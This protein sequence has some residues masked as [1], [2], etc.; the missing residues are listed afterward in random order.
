MDAKLLEAAEREFAALVEQQF[1]ALLLLPD[2]EVEPPLIGY[3]FDPRDP[4]QV[5][6]CKQLIL[7]ALAARAWWREEA[8]PWAQPLPLTRKECSA[9]FNLRD[10]S[11]QEQ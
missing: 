2:D 4:E 7:Q 3:S 1:E 10:A 11:G 9:L 5:A 8:P 6:S